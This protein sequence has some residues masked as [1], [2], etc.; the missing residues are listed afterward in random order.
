M[1]DFCIVFSGNNFN[2]N[3]RAHF[4]DDSTNF[5]SQ[6]QTIDK[7]NESNNRNYTACD[8]PNVDRRNVDSHTH[9]PPHPLLNNVLLNVTTVDALI[10]YVAANGDSYEDK[11]RTEHGDLM[12]SPFW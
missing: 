12:R 11:V 3:N 4:N 5:D 2:Q 9:H 8:G 1:I 10:D 6:R 7:N